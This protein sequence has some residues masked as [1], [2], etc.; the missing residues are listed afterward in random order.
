[1]L[2]MACLP[3]DMFYSHLILISFGIHTLIHLKWNKIKPVFKLRTAALQSVFFVTIICTIYTLNKPEAYTEWG[4][5]VIIFI[6]PVLFCLNP[7][8]I[9][10]HGPQLFMA[11]ALVCTATV[12]YLYFDAFITIRHYQLPLKTIF[13]SSFT[14][15]NF[16]EP[17][18]MHATFF[19]MQLMLALVYI[20]SV[21][22]KE[23]VFYKKLFYLICSSILTAGLIQLGSKSIFIV[24][25]I[26]MNIALPW[27]LLKGAARLKY[28]MVSV[29][30]S[31]LVIA[32][33]L[34]SNTFKERYITELKR[35]LS[36]SAAGE[37][38]DSRLARWDAVIQ[39]I[40]KSPLIGYGSGSEMGLL[41][42]AFFNKKLYNSYLNRLNAHSEY[43]SFLVKSGIIGLL[44]YL[45][46]LAFGFNNS[47]RQKDLLFFTFMTLVAIVSLSENL[48][49]V[50]KGIFF[51]SFFFTFF[52]FADEDAGSNLVENQ[53]SE[54][55][56]KTDFQL[57]AEDFRLTQ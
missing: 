42:D 10:K 49:D 35:D 19:S 40:G 1:M 12:A 45:A 46:T 16:S 4:R 14:N 57:Q 41:Q 56:I 23:R 34:N 37:P 20:L 6:L 33:I 48:L 29:S 44:V 2:L 50:D 52:I 22:I 9:K 18:N 43:L 17:I 38:T 5:R 26:I 27:F 54:R 53:K 21:L 55:P 7:L 47:F 13:S 30:F 25:I 28:L 11:F 24:L 15:H 3:F 32:G 36:K 39:L 31:V 51:Y 8:D